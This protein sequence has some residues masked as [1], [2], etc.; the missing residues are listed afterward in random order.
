MKVLKC[1]K[2]HFFDVEKYSSCPYCEG[3]AA[4]VSNSVPQFTKE[5]AEYAETVAANDGEDVTVA[6]EED[7][8]REQT[9][10]YQWTPSADVNADAAADVPDFHI[11]EERF[12][13]VV[14]WLV[15]VEGAERGRDYRLLAGRNYI[16]RSVDMDISIPDDQQLSR[17]RHCSVIYDPRSFRFVVLPG[18]SS[19]TMLNGETLNMPHDLKDG[20]VITCGSTKLCFIAYCREGRDWE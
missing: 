11:Q 19:L 16:G 13:P 3:G 15:C 6:Y 1:Q 12:E 9:I 5:D 4:T 18:D 7:R 2:G 17:E 20:D 10:A 8:D 14:G